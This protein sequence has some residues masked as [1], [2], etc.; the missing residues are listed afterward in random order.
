MHDLIRVAVVDAL[1]ERLHQNGG[2]VLREVLAGRDLL[3]E[4]SAAA[5]VRHDVVPLFALVGLVHFEYV[6]MIEL[7]QIND[8]APEHFLFKL[9]HAGFPEN[10][11]CSF[12]L[13]FLVHTFA[14]FPKCSLA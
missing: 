9:V 10:F 2:V 7:F 5:Q 3:E 1:Q 4:L 14:N 8:F 12:L 6:G 11:D 13:V